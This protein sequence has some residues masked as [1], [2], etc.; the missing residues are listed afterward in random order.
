MVTLQSPALQL[1][2]VLRHL[3]NFQNA[4]QSILLQWLATSTQ[5]EMVFRKM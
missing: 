1:E 5:V 4:F 3:E 2:N